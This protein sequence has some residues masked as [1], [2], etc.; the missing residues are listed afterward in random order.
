MDNEHRNAAQ[1][2]YDAFKTDKNV[3]VEESYEDI[4]LFRKGRLFYVGDD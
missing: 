4:M 1:L 3:V 2:M